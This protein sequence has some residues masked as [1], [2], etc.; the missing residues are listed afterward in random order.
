MSV[1]LFESIKRQAEDL[2]PDEKSRLG[3]YLLEQA[4]QTHTKQ[5]PGVDEETAELKRKQ[6]MKWL[7]ANDEQ[8]GGQ[9]VALD[10]D[11]LV[12]TGRTFREVTEA[13]R[14]AGKADAFVTYLPKRDELLES[15]GWQ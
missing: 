5:E 15:G 9:Y 13:A 6:H 12:C 2:T 4:G 11:L 1:E 14:A 3:V 7:K 8:F 10:G